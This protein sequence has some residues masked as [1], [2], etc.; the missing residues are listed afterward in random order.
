MLFI[1]GDDHSVQVFD[2]QLFSRGFSGFIPPLE[3]AY[4]PER[5]P[6]AG[7]THLL[8]FKKC[9]PGM[10]I[11]QIPGSIRATLAFEQANCIDHPLIPVCLAILKIIQRN[12]D[13]IMPAGRERE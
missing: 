13:V 9:L 8:H 7:F 5:I 2:Q 1:Y 3:H 4:C 10:P 11:L 6:T 12:Q